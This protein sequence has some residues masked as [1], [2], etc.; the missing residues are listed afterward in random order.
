MLYKDNN[1]YAL[2][3]SS[4]TTV[5]A[6]AEN[7]A[8]SNACEQPVL[9]YFEWFLV[10]GHNTGPDDG[11]VGGSAVISFAVPS[12]VSLIGIFYKGVTLSLARS[13]HDFS[14]V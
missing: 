3:R 13:S 2:F 6:S 10:F 14:G 11:I 4:K 1:E 7:T 9:N 5:Y 8:Q 12:A